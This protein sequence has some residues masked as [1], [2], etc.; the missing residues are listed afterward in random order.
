MLAHNAATHAHC[1]QADDLKIYLLGPFRREAFRL[2]TVLLLL[3]N[4][5]SP[6]DSQPDTFMRKAVSCTQCKCACTSAGNL[7]RHMLTH[8]GAKPFNCSQCNKR[9][10]QNLKMHI[11][12]HSGENHFMCEKCNYSCNCAGHLKNHKLMHT[13]EKFFACKQCNYYCSHSNRLKCHMLSHT[14]EK[15]FFCMY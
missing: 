11:L 8:S 15:P 12:I 9:T 10:P 13:G 3:H 2:H 14:G 5:L 4:S 1:T 7:K 6:Q